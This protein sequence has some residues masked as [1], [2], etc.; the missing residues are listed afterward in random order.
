MKK[1]K[2]LKI[3]II[4]IVLLIFLDQIFKI[5]MKFSNTSININTSLIIE[6]EP[7]IRE[8]GE[9]MTV[10]PVS[11][12]AILLIAKYMKSDNSFIKF[13]NK[14]VVGFLLAGVI[15]NCI[16]NLWNGHTINYINIV[17]F[18]YI[19]LSYIYFIVTWI[20]MAMILTKFTI[21]RAR[22]R[23]EKRNNS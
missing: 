14:I 2:D 1:N 23:N 21:E 17:G 15:S 4:L 9:T 7:T 13:N 5:Y 20:G 8:T 6:L 19:N 22:E 12:I 18:S 16:D 10:I 3:L 11:I